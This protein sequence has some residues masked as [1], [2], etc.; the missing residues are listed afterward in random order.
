[1]DQFSSLEARS[2]SHLSSNHGIINDINQD[3][4]QDIDHNSHH[5]NHDHI[6]NH[7]HSIH[8]V[9]NPVSS[10]KSAVTKHLWL[11]ASL[12]VPTTHKNLPEIVAGQ[13]LGGVRSLIF[14]LEDAVLERDLE[15]G[16]DQLASSL[17]FLEPDP[18]RLRFV[19]VRNPEV[20]RQVLSMPNIEAIDGFVLPKISSATL[21]SYLLMMSET[22]QF[23]L[24]P[25]LETKEVFEESKMLELRNMLEGVRSQILSLR[26]GGNDLLNYL[27]LRR[28]KGKTLYQTPLSSVISRLVS[29]FKPHGYNLTSPV[30]DIAYDDQTLRQEVQ[31]DLE[32]GLFGK[33]AIHP[34][35]VAVIEQEYRVGRLELRLAEAILQEDASA[36]FM[37]DHHMC[38]PATHRNWAREVVARA[39]IYGVGE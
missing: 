22:S 19:R 30:Y 6:T 1:M 39:E 24:M 14:C 18:N 9:H 20:M 3:A 7:D 34:S 8:P 23:S 25:T 16:L 31:L 38:E 29:I 5:I 10:P 21:G 37:I 12:Y 13:R 36:V 28:I 26:I 32:H 27:S 17:P 4:N 35:Q 33:T 11:G 2:D 15:F